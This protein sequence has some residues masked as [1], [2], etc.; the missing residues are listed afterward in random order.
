MQKDISLAAGTIDTST[1][2][3]FL[4]EMQYR[5]ACKFAA[6]KSGY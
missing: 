2:V 6:I 1:P 3:Y 5:V 4:P